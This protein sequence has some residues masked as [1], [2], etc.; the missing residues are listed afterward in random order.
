[1]LPKAMDRKIDRQMPK[2]WL[3]TKLMEETSL[4]AHHKGYMLHTMSSEEHGR[5]ENISC[6]RND[7]KHRGRNGFPE[8]FLEFFFTT[9]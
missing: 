5:A 7:S 2:H 4:V 3:T 9:L 6:S 1:M 8:F